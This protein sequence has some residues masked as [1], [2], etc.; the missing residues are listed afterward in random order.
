MSIYIDRTIEVISILSTSITLAEIITVITTITTSTIIMT[1]TIAASGRLVNNIEVVLRP[2]NLR[3]LEK[4]LVFGLS[5]R[6]LPSERLQK[7][8]GQRLAVLD[9]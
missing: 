4:F 9:A 8:L 5:K 7:N 3:I 1:I 6:D 2:S